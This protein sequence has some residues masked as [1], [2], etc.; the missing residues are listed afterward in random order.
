MVSVCTKTLIFSTQRATHTQT[1][2]S[3]HTDIDIDTDQIHKDTCLKYLMVL[4]GE[5]EKICLT[6]SRLQLT[7]PSY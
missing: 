6:S 3:T 1:H 4:S 2:T 7:A 5:H